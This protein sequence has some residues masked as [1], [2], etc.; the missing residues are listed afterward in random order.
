MPSSLVVVGHA[1]PRSRSLAVTLA[2][3]IAELDGSVTRPVIP[4]LTSWDMRRPGPIQATAQSSNRNNVLCIL[5]LLAILPKIIRQEPAL[6]T[7]G[8]KQTRKARRDARRI[9]P[10]L[11]GGDQFFDVDQFGGVIAGIAGVT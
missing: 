8:N 11:A 4:A 3:T 9:L 2:P 7:C 5:P 1:V 10:F 6:G